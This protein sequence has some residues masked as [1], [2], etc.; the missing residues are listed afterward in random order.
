MKNYAFLAQLKTQGRIDREKGRISDLKLCY[1]VARIYLTDYKTP[2]LA[3]RLA[4]A[5][6]YRGFDKSQNRRGFGFYSKA[7]LAKAVKDNVP[8]RVGGAS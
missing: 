6:Y 8:S 1:D 4:L 5:A 2:D 7:A 3:R